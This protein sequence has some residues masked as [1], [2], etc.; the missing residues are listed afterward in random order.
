MTCDRRDNGD[1]NPKYLTKK[2]G[3]KRQRHPNDERIDPCRDTWDSRDADEH[4]ETLM[5]RAAPFGRHLNH[6]ALGFR[7]PMR[8]N[9]MPLPFELAGAVC[10]F[11]DPG[12][13]KA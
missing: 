1:R 2:Q 3:F 8:D 5:R 11:G 6:R 7:D 12:A 9:V 10:L 4:L 13:P